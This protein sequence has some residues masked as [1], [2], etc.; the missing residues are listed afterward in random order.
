MGWT[1]LY[2]CNTLKFELTFQ[3][4]KFPAKDKQTSTLLRLSLNTIS[5]EAL[6][7]FFLIPYTYFL[8]NFHHVTAIIIIVK[9]KEILNMNILLLYSALFLKIYQSASTIWIYDHPLQI[10]LIQVYSTSATAMWVVPDK[11]VLYL[12]GFISWFK[13]VT[14][15]KLSSSQF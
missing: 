11:F 13:N 6:L 12:P 8:F 2:I 1:P 15:K 3:T 9:N 14:S 10:L 4:M 7:I 5:C